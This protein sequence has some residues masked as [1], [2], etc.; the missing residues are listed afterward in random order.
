MSLVPHVAG[1][2]DWRFRLIRTSFGLNS[3]YIESV[4]ETI[5]MLK[6]YGNWSF[7]EA[8]S[9]PIKIRSWFANRLVKE[10]E[11]QVENNK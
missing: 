8:Y 7:A 10:F 9:L 3:E 6:H 4:Y 5:F 11:K 1:N 2:P